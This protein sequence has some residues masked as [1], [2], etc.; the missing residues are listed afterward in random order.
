MTPA[1]N[2]GSPRAAPPTGP[3]REGMIF[4]ATPS[5]N[6]PNIASSRRNGAIG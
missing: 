1:S 6:E 4:M 5:V 2:M 3:S